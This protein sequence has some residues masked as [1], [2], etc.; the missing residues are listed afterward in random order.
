VFEAVPGT[1]DAQ[2]LH[3]PTPDTLH[4]LVVAGLSPHMFVDESRRNSQ[5][6]SPRMH[7][8]IRVAPSI[9]P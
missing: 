9:T 3:S 5:R 2:P 4:S 7:I 1:I 6:R 8:S